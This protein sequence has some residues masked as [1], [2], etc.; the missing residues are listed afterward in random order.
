MNGLFQKYEGESRMEATI[1]LLDKCNFNCKH[2]YAPKNGNQ[3]TIKQIEQI[4]TLSEA[5]KIDKFSLLGG[6]PLLY[7]NLD[8]VFELL[9]KVSIYTN[10]KDIA[11]HVDVLKKAEAVVISIDGYKETND[12]VRGDGAWRIAIDALSTLRKHKINTLLRCSYHSG[13]LKDVKP[14]L[15]KI[16]I[17]YD[18][19]IM[20]FPRTD[21]PVLGANEQV[22]LYTLL[23]SGKNGGSFVHQPNFFQY[24]GEKGR[25][26]AGVYRVNF[27]SDGKI[28]PCNM[29]FDYVLGELGIHP[30]VLQANIDNYLENFK[31]TPYECSICVHGEVC[32]GGCLLSK[33]YATCPLK[34]NLDLFVVCEHAGI[35]TK[36]V[37]K[38]Y[39]KMREI[40]RNVV[41]C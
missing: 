31:I 22:N 37:K 18:I 27:C 2:C 17:P 16:S 39:H 26:P 38:R 20:F 12:E 5:M 14:L 7:P 30:P 4:K 33:Q 9:P 6:E 15:E 34:Q 41:T 24:I 36:N 1:Y 19:P 29:N 3:L 32:K 8:A 35:D 13:N 25:C 23:M 40:I 10:G 21:K 28:T 11:D